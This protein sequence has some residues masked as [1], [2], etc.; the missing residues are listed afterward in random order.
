MPFITNRTE[1]CPEELNHVG[2]GVIPR[3]ATIREISSNMWKESERCFFFVS[4]HLLFLCKKISFDLCQPV[5]TWVFEAWGP[6]SGSPCGTWQDE[7]SRRIAP[8]WLGVTQGMETSWNLIFA[9]NLLS[10]FNVAFWKNENRQL[11]EIGISSL[12]ISI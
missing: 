6:L 12:K 2:Y 7:R 5:G 4:Q 9:T 11:F 8:M 10:L 3:E 1:T